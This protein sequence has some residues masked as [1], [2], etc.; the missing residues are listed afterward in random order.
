VTV[1]PDWWFEETSA[2]TAV[3]RALGQKRLEGLGFELPA[4]L[5]GIAAAGGIVAYLEENEPAAVARIATLSAWRPGHR[6][7][8]ART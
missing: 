6:I 1:R 5:P 7:T 4:D 3:D 2:K 8:Q